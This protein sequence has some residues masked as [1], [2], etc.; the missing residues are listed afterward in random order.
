[1]NQIYLDNAATTSVRPEVVEEMIKILTNDFGNP[2]STYA[3]GRHTKALI[4]TAR[5]TIAKQFNV[6]SGE[7]IFTSCGTEGNNWIIRSSIRDLGVKRIITT[8][9]EHHCTLY[10]IQQMEK[11]YNTKIDFVNVLPNSEID[12]AH[13]EELLKDEEPTLISLMHVNNEVGTILDLKRVADL[14]QQYNALFHSDTVQS[15]GK[16]EIP[17]DEIPIDFIVASAHKFHGPKGA[18]FV[19][20]RK[21][22][23]LKPL[24]VGGEQE[25]G[26][27]AGTEAPHQVVGMS[28]ALELSYQDLNK[29]RKT[30]TELRDYCKSQLE[31][32]FEGVAFNGNGNTFYNVLN[33]RLPFSSEKA[34]MMLFQL[35]MKG[36]AVSRG[37]ACQSGSQK[38]SHVLAE[39]LNDTELRK[40]S[41]RLSFGHENTK[42]EIDYLIDVLKNV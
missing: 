12:Y 31:D 3:I 38:P 23:V 26:M 36:I 7:I 40:P 17:L 20:I 42:E 39:F 27:R 24:I 10:S 13:L 34:A 8:R 22:N 19:F 41:L 9:M 5:K 33:I 29:D 32:I 2:S 6:T 37:S 21:K 35:D 4:E 18:G 1:M 15:V 28:K 11:E 16:I 14:A 25:K 30:I